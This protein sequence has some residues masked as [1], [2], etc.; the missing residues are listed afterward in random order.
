[1]SISSEIFDA[2]LESA[3]LDR[4]TFAQLV[5][6]HVS[7]GG[8]E[9][10]HHHEHPVALV[11]KRV[12]AAQLG[13]RVIGYLEFDALLILRDGYEWFGLGTDLSQWPFVLP[14]DELDVVKESNEPTALHRPDIFLCYIPALVVEEPVAVATPGDASEEHFE[15]LDRLLEV[16]MERGECLSFQVSI[17]QDL[18]RSR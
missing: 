5:V 4:V 9:V 17:G 6:L 7:V 8:L 1:V 15:A 3:Q 11:V 18:L 12:T 14:A 10:A 16:I 13:H 2:E